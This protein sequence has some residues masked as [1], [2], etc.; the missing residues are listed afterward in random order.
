MIKWVEGKIDILIDMKYYL[1]LKV[2]DIC[3]AYWQC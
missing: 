1:K 2:V 3:G